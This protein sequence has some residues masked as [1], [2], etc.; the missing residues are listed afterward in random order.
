M[1]GDLSAGD[2][3]QAVPLLDEDATVREPPARDLDHVRGQV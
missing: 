1:I 2:G 3:R